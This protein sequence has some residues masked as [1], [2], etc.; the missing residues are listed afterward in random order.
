[1]RTNPPRLFDVPSKPRAKPRKL[2]HVYDAGPGYDERDRV[3]FLC[4]HCGHESEWMLIK[5]SDAKRGIPCP[6]CNEPST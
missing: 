6:K 2:M 3:K 1:M 4:P 5:C